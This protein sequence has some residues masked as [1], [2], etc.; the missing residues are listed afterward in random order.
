MN[1]G[2][3]LRASC[4]CGEVALEARGAPM[5]AAVCY[6]DDC[7]AAGRQIEALPGA[8]PV[9]DPDAGTP[10]VMFR[11]DRLRC[12][13][14]QERLSAHKLTPAS[15]TNRYVASCC[16]SAMY[17]GF[18][19][20]KHWVD[21]FRSRIDGP[22]PPIQARVCTRFRPEGTELPGDAPAYRSFPP[23]MIFRII[24]AKI[25]MMFGR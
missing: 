24:G 1:S 16:N 21:V 10:L 23:A 14:G 3:V 8:A 25:G 6:C 22:A 5:F 2:S 12:V 11:K 4:I 19:D 18:D 15:A 13:C 17:L 20:A 7:Q 9:L